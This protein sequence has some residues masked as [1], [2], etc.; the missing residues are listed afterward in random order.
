[1]RIAIAEA[2][3]SPLHGDVP[4]GCLVVDKSNSIIGRGRN[5][6]EALRDP[7]GHAELMAIRQS[8]IARGSWRLDGCTIYTTLEPCVMCAGAIIHSRVTRVVIGCDD[9]KAGAMGSVYSIGLE[10]RLNHKVNL[11]R[12]VLAAECSEPLSAF[13]RRLRQ[14]GKK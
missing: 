3:E 2:V 1:M 13:F 10:N 7:L 6:K 4:V 14:Q 12:G 9:P 5:L 11:S 8:A